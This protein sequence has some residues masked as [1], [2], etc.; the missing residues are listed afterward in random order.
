MVMVRNKRVYRLYAQG[1]R[2]N[3]S[4]K[5]KDV[6]AITTHTFNIV[7]YFQN[8]CVIYTPTNNK[9][10]GGGVMTLHYPGWYI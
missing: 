1:N 9:R 5:K 4:L 8:L 7:F 10:K 6:T 3:G 2:D